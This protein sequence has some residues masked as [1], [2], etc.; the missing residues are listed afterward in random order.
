MREKIEILSLD[1]FDSYKEEMD[2]V[3]R[4]QKHFNQGIGWHYYLDLAWIMREVRKL[5]RGSLILDAGAGGGLAQFILAE[6]GY[7]V[8][9]ADF[10]DRNFSSRYSGRYGKIIYYLNDQ[11]Q[12]FD[13]QYLKHLQ[14]TYNM[15]NRMKKK[16]I[17]SRI[18]AFFKKNTNGHHP[19]KEDTLSLIDQNRY[20]P[21]NDD[22]RDVLNDNVPEYCGRIF[23]CKSDL[24]DLSLLPDNFVDGVVSVSALEHNDHKDIEKCVEEILRVTKPGGQLF[25]TVSASQS[26]DWFHDPSKGW[27]YSE[28]SL[29]K[30]FQMSE[31]VPSN[32]SLKDSFFQKIKEEKNE[33]HKRLSRFYF[34]SGNNG[35]PWG[36]WEPKYQPVGI[37]KIKHKKKVAHEPK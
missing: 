18:S 14:K 34:K 5:P 33:L 8:I 4:M 6:S 11:N 20:A 15:P 32:F 37:I 28:A 22:H 12:V 26:E 16:R 3:E 19:R 1:L 24:K 29:R 27:C 9:S 25:I 23:V 2:I 17:I 7:N 30:L 36:K 35:M 31:D 10:A 13:S 21:Q